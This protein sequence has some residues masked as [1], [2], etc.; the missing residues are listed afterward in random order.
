MRSTR[1]CG[2]DEVVSKIVPNT[3]PYLLHRQQL[4]ANGRPRR[5]PASD[6]CISLPAMNL[7]PVKSEERLQN[8]STLLFDDGQALLN[9][10]IEVI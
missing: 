5:I 2:M 6:L 4:T 9:F 3:Q 7:C 1:L 10:D 8:V